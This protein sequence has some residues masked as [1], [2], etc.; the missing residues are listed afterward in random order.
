[1]PGPTAARL[2]DGRLHL[3]YGPI[4]LVI[5]VAG[6]REAVARS[7]EAMTRRF[8][9]VLDELVAEIESLRADVASR[10]HVNGETARRMQVATSSVCG[11]DFATSMIAV[12]GSVADTIA[13]AGWKDVS[14]RRLIV[15]NGG[16]IAIRQLLDESITIGVVDDVMTG[17]LTGR[18][19]VAGDSGV[20]GV[21]TSGWGGRSFSLG[22]AD[23]VTVLARTAALADVAATLIAN[24]VDLPGHTSV[25]RRPAVDIKHDSDLGHRLVTCGVGNLTEDEID[26]ALAAGVR[27]A[28]SALATGDVV[29]V[30][31]SLR[32]RRRVV[33]PPRV[34]LDAGA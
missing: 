24:A 26:E 6:E 23:A 13:D 25:V 33:L 22:I 28:E 27:R 32:G 9:T 10:P 16:D 21:A 18:L 3:Q 15:N 17:R 2:D 20:G 4:D 12:A 1:M 19:H 31:L 14:L 8:E 11:E 29:G 34:A 7:E 30:V 5:G